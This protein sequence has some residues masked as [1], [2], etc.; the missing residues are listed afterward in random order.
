MTDT[1]VKFFSYNMSGAPQ[2]NQ[3]A[4][5]GIDMLDACLC[6]GFGSVSLTSLEVS[7]NVATATVNSGHNFP[8]IVGVNN[9]TPG[10]GPVILI[11]GATP[12]ALNGE[13]RIASVPS[14]TQFTFTTSGIS[15]QTATGTITAKRAPAGFT[16]VYSGTNLAA[17]RANAI[18]STRLFLHVNNTSTR[19]GNVVMYETMSDINT[20]TGASPSS[21][22]YKIYLDNNGVNRPWW[23]FADDRCFYALVMSNDALPTFVSGVLFFG[24][25]I[26]FLSTDAYH[27]GLIGSADGACT[28]N[29][30]NNST[31]SALA[32]SYTQTGT[33]IGML[34]T[35]SFYDGTSLGEYGETYP[36]R[37]G[38]QF[39]AWPISVF[40][41]NYIQRGLMPGFYAP[42][43]ARNSIT[44]LTLITDIINYPDKK[45]L[46][47]SNNGYS[48]AFDITGPWR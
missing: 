14:T 12:T 31:V 15:N 2:L 3:V 29:Y 1:S 24:D 35:G 21:N 32:R 26:N 46:T 30:L 36:S 20:G 6:T 47:I 44:H 39:L 9:A 7:N 43:H 8:M 16:K 27:C 33:T 19:Q 34:R 41:A 10:V 37:V 5:N 13:W 17:Y 45:L 48:I 42:Q 23:V 4:G 11:E 22:Y 25:I 18:D 40:Q 38:N 28:L